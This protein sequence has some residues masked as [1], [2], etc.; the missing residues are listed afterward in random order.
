MDEQQKWLA[1]TA[2][3][4]VAA[5]V[6]IP[7]VIGSVVFGALALGFIVKWQTAKHGERP[8]W[9]KSVV[10]LYRERGE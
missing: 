8:W 2:I 7:T 1:A 4:L 5:L 6:L 10:T 3:S 9:S